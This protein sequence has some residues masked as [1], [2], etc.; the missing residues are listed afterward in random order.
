MTMG[1]QWTIGAFDTF[2]IRAFS[3][4]MRARHT[5]EYGPL[6]RGHIHKREGKKPKNKKRGGEA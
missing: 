2:L 3:R 6:N 1:H 4:E 5:N